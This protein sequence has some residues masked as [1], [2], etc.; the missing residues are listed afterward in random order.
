METKNESK[1]SNS[2][3]SIQEFEGQKL[4]LVAAMHLDAI[5][6]KYP[7]L[8]PHISGEET[9]TDSSYNRTK[10]SQL[11]ERICELLEEIIAERN[12]NPEN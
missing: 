11:E 6:T 8:K 4:V 10:V 1:L 9:S 12:D 5:Q 3:K 2:I 7:N